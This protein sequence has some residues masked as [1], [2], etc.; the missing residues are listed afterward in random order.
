[1]VFEFTALGTHWW[2]TIFDQLDATTHAAVK[3]GC[4]RFVTTY[5]N[6]YSRFKPDSLVSLLNKNR[7]LPEP[8]PDFCALL[9]YGKK[10]YERTNDSFNILTGHILEARGY[11]ATYSFQEKP[12]ETTLAGNPATDLRISDTAIELLHGNIDIGGFGKGYLIDLLADQLQAN[13]SI[14]HFLINGGGDMYG[15]TNAEQPIK[16]LLE[17]PTVAQTS[18]GKTTVYHQGFAASSPHKRRWRD[19]KG[20]EHTH[21]IGDTVTDATFI[22]ATNAADADAFAT[23]ALLVNQTDLEQLIATEPVCV[24]RF[25]ATNNTLWR[26][27]DF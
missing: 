27:K 8:D 17:H 7:V 2:I 11:D 16:I 25:N 13:Y 21:I 4:V 6:R 12:D 9:T 23:T 3:D 14:T 1:M 5:E 15:T 24:A 10:L 26:M 18:I 19:K 22:K 20:T